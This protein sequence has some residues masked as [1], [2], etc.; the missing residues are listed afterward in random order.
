MSHNHVSQNIIT[1]GTS[2]DDDDDED[3]LKRRKTTEMY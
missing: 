1:F 3:E 2:N